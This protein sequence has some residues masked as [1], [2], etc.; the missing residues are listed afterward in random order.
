MILFQKWTKHKVES[1]ICCVNR[2]LSEKRHKKWNQ[3]CKQKESFFVQSFY[4]FLSFDI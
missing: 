4:Y 1:Y 3:E 2:F